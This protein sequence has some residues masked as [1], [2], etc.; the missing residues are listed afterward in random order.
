MPDIN[1]ADLYIYKS[2][3]YDLNKFYST[4]RKWYS[5]NKFVP[6]EK[7]YKDKAKDFGTEIVTE[8]TAFRKITGYIRYWVDVEV[9]SWETQEVEVV[10]GGKKVKRTKSRN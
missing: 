7:V 5:D 2:G 6:F 8:W 10:I 3:I 1:E 4:I 9:K